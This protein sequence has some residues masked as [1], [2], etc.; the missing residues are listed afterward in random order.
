MIDDIGVARNAD[1]TTPFISNNTLLHFIIAGI[2]RQKNGSP[3][4]TI[5]N[6]NYLWVHLHPLQ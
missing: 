1:D 3:I 4:V 5:T 6:E 2:S